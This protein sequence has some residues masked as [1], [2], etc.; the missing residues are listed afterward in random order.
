MGGWM[1]MGNI[2]TL[3]VTQK[4]LRF[5]GVVRNGNGRVDGYQLA[6][7]NRME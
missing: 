5:T 1:S 7:M 2:P 3:D 6:D 4:L